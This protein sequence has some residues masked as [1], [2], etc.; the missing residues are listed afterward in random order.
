MPKDKIKTNINKETAA[1]AGA[2]YPCQSS[3]RPIDAELRH[4]HPG[5]GIETISPVQIENKRDDK[6]MVI[7][8]VYPE[9]T[10][11]VKGAI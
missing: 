6:Q 4:R 5:I 10:R 3:H 11:G 1:L 9:L 8:P 2:G 7:S